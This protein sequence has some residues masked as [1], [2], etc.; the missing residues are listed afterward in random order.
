MNF[1]PILSESAGLGLPQGFTAS[2][3][4]NLRREEITSGRCGTR[5][6]TKPV[7]RYPVHA[8]PAGLPFDFRVCHSANRPF[9]MVPEGGVEPPSLSPPIYNLLTSHS[10]SLWQSRVRTLPADH[11]FSCTAPLEIPIQPD[12]AANLGVAGCSCG[13]PCAETSF[14]VFYS[15]TLTVVSRLF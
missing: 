7:L 6:H 3:W 2:F 10:S 15:L 5:T 13:I 8:V 4:V 14:A 12:I 9:K 1:T 11:K